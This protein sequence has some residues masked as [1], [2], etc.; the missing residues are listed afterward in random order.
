MVSF[1]LV[2]SITKVMCTGIYINYAQLLNPVH[3]D[4]ELIIFFI[5]LI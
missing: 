2:L 1:M 4:T 5:T 3:L